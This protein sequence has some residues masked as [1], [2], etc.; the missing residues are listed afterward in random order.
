MKRK[1]AGNETRFDSVHAQ[2]D[3]A[4]RQS[5]GVGQFVKFKTRWCPK[6]GKDKLPDGGKKR[7]EFYVCKDCIEGNKL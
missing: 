1:G 5:V 3:K 7:G 2:I 6:C 4:K